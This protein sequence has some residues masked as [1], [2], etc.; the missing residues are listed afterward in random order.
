MA[1]FLK[2]DPNL[3][4]TANSHFTDI[5]T[6]RAAMNSDS[7]AFLKYEKHHQ[8]FKNAKSSQPINGDLRL[9]KKLE[10]IEE[11]KAKERALHKRAFRNMSIGQRIVSEKEERVL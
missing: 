10:L 5:S 8:S 2:A 11:G 1:V 3:K 7:S 9:K 6:P 4:I